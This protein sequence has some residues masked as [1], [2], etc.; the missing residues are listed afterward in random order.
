MMALFRSAPCDF[1][2]R[3]N[4]ACH[5]HRLTI[6]SRACGDVLH[7]GA[8]LFD[9]AGL[10]IGETVLIHGALQA[11]ALRRSAR[12]ALRT[13]VITTAGSDRNRR[14]RSSCRCRYQLHVALTSSRREI[15][16]DA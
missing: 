15:A 11:S 10:K 12:Q 1:V 7:R 4:T 13:R 6:G 8:N 2:W 16:D 14:L 9:R 3:I 5:S